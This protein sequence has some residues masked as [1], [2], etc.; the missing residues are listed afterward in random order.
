MVIVAT[1]V[2]GIYKLF[3]LF[4]KRKER[5][6]IIERLSTGID[7]QILGNLFQKPILKIESYNSWAIK[8]GLLLLGVG[9]GVVVAVIIDISLRTSSIKIDYGIRDAISVL[10]SA[11]AAV[12]G[13]IGLLISYLIEKKERNRREEK[14]SLNNH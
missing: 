6:A 8:A 13:G 2:F 3:E 7:P 12:F 1:I 11:C 14:D 10:Y 4:V 5:I 9:L